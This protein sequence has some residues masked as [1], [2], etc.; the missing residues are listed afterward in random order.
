MQN[1][2]VLSLLIIGTTAA[3]SSEVQP[4]TSCG[5][6]VANRLP[7]A[8]TASA[9]SPLVSAETQAILW[10]STPPALLMAWVAP[11]HETRYVGPSAA[12]TPLNGATS[13]TM[14]VEW[15]AAPELPLL[16]AARAAASVIAATAGQA[17]SK[18]PWAGRPGTGLSSPAASAAEPG[19]LN[20]AVTSAT[21]SGGGQGS[22]PAWRPVTRPP[23]P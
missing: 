13:A 8:G 7:T 9:G 5:W 15:L 16:H 3:A 18:R 17:L 20:I 19:D 4:M 10:P 22:E 23:S 2:T 14:S 11:L 6:C 21:A 12:S 1:I